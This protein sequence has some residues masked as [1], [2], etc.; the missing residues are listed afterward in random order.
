[1]FF[2]D[3][4]ILAGRSP[5][6]E[7]VLGAELPGPQDPMLAGMHLKWIASAL[8]SSKADFL[9]VGGH[10]PV[11]SIGSHGPTPLLELLLKPL[12]EE[13]GAHY[14]CGHDHDLE[15][16]D[17]GH[18]VTYIV[19]GSG[20]AGCCYDDSNRDKVPKG[21]VKFAATGKDGS[22]HQSMPFPILGGFASVRL[23]TESMEIVLHA[24]NGTELHRTG[25]IPRR[26]LS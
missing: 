10:Y 16:I 6:E 2:I 8:K 18:G 7:L 22:G 13:A 19:T 20:G 17:D 1:M 3:T 12:L 11:Y 4:V 23:E 14:L 5:T 26:Q 9:L 15:H 24:H 25:K 21:S